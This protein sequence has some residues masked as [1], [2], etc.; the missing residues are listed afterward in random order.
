MSS[1]SISPELLR[2]HVGRLPA[3]PQAVL[4]LLAELRRDD[5]SADD[6]AQHIVHDQA[7]TAR[8]L[9]LAN[10]AFYGAPGRVATIRDAIQML[11]R[12][13]L[14]ALLT[15][16][17][18]S[19]QFSPGRAAGFD[20]AA[21][22]RHALGTAL[23]AQ[24]LALET[25]ADDDLAFTAGLLH[26]MGRLLLAAHYPAELALALAQAQADDSPLLDAEQAALGTD[27]ACIG[28]MV[29][30]HWSFPP[31]VAAAIADHHAPPTC[32][33]SAAAAPALADLVHVADAITHALGLNGGDAD[34]V[35]DI[36]A[37]AWARLALSPAQ[38]LRVF[39]RTEQGVLGLCQALGV[40]A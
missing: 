40:S 37:A 1:V 6:C 33:G 8:T 15:T 38:C 16:A 4:Q 21:F 39:D 10:S 24:S 9:R 23:A 34:M 20:F 32:T 36:D 29:A 18:V 31:A 30:A 17:V 13:T 27:H 26:D 19:G 25:G 3:L 28:A 2:G 12:R 11:G 14:G 35:P 5:S 22:W 7:M